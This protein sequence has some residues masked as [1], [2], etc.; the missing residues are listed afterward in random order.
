MS[1]VDGNLQKLWHQIEELP[2]L[3]EVIPRLDIVDP[4]EMS[5][6]SYIPEPEPSDGGSNLTVKV[7]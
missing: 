5:S 6:E 7:F 2:K 4:F 1:L 3:V